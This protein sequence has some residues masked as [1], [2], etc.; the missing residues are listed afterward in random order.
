MLIQRITITRNVAGLQFFVGHKPAA[1]NSLFGDSAKTNPLTAWEEADYFGAWQALVASPSWERQ[2]VGYWGQSDGETDLRDFSM[3]WQYDQALNGNVF[4]TGNISIPPT[5]GTDS[6]VVYLAFGKTS[7]EMQRTI[8]ALPGIDLSASQ[9]KYVDH[10]RAYLA[11]LKMPGTSKRS[12]A[13]ESL[14]ESS[15]LILK[16]IEDKTYSGAMWHPR[17]T[18]GATREWNRALP[19]PETTQAIMFAGPGFVSRRQCV[20]GHGRL[21]NRNCHSESTSHAQ[22]ESDDG[23]WSFGSRN[24]SREGELPQ[25]FWVDGHHAWDAYQ[26]DQ[27]AMPTLLAYRLWQKGVDLTKYWPMVKKSADFLADMG[28]WTQNERWEENY[29]ISPNTAGYVISSLVAASQIAFGMGDNESGTRYLALADQWSTKTGDNV[30]TWT[31]TTNG[32]IG[33]PYG[34]GKYYLRLAGAGCDTNSGCAPIWDAPWNPNDNSM[35]GIFNGGGLHYESEIVDS[36]FLALVRLGVRS[37]KNYFIRETLPEIDSLLKRNTPGGP[38][39]YRYRFDGYGENG[40]GRLWPLLSGER[41]HYELQWM[42]ENGELTASSMDGMIRF[43]ESF[44]SPEGIFSEQV[45]DE[46]SDAGKATGSA[47]PL[48]WSHAEYLMLLRSAAEMSVSDEIDLVRKR[49]AGQ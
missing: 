34:N 2:S 35:M 1:A 9:K 10:W 42:K 26:A 25:N 45:W 18:L 11:T 23:D 20:Y 40:R 41:Y 12:T 24:H 47:S 15:A 14:V 44:A 49:Y 7:D 5:A 22:F 29:G 3:D 8:S 32:K 16:S 4:L 39:W 17:R 27:A 37:A 31:F 21:C 6:V 33:S 19:I 13:Q 28:P 36:S 48:A 43:Y 30:D 38:G 46:G